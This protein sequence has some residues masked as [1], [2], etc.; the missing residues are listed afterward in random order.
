[1]VVERLLLDDIRRVSAFAREHEDEFLQLVTAKSKRE[2][3]KSLR[4]SKSE[5]EQVQARISKLDGIM[6]RLYE[7]NIEGKVSDGR[8][9]K[10]STTYEA[11]QKQL[12]ICAAELRVY[13]HDTKEKSL[14]AD[15]F[16]EKVK[17]YTDI[18]ELD[19]E[20][21]R[22]LIEKIIVHKVEKVDGH[23]V[24]RITIHYN[25][26]G[27]FEVPMPAEEEKTA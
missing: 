23:R 5:F 22:E 26:I 9:A 1:M 6:Q 7:D 3:E 25:G 11:E 24:Q 8:Y 13:I 10:L 20:I 27:A 16:L 14:N 19:A 12:E 18:R 21:I 17:K 4:D 2:A 15:Y